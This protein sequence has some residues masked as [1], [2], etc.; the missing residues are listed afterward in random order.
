MKAYIK[1]NEENNSVIAEVTDWRW[2]E[3]EVL[4]YIGWIKSKFLDKGKLIQISISF[5]ALRIIARL[6]G[7]H[8]VDGS[9]NPPRPTPPI[10]ALNEDERE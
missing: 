5:R 10:A 2:N 8:Y 1:F 4:D 9:C 3:N 7:S 6:E